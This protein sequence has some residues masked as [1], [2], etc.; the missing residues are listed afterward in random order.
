METLRY[1]HG[2]DFQFAD[3]SKYMDKGS[4][5][6]NGYWQERGNLVIQGGCD[7]SDVK[8]SGCDYTDRYRMFAILKLESYGF[9]KPHCFEALEHCKGNVDD[10]LDL[11]YAQYFPAY[12]KPL[13]NSALDVYSE[14]EILEMRQDEMSSLQSIYDTMFEEQQP[15]RVWQLKLKID[16]LLVHS[17]SE[18]RKR[19][20]ASHEQHKQVANNGKPLALCR[21]FAKGK[22]KYGV[23]CRFSHKTTDTTIN[24]IGGVETK[25]LDPDLDANWF[26]LEIR[27]AAKSRYPFEAP[28]M[29][30]KTTCP[31]IPPM[32]C[33][34]ITRRIAEESQQMAKDGMAS[35][36]TVSDLLQ[37]DDEI[38]TFLRNDRYEFL[39][40]KNSIF[41]V[42]TDADT[43][44]SSDDNSKS[45]S[46]HY[47]K[48]TTGRSDVTKVSLDQRRKDDLNLVQKFMDKQKQTNYKAMLKT[49][50]SL[51]AWSMMTEILETIGRSQVVVISGETG[52]GK[53]TQVPQ[54]ILDEWM[55]RAAMSTDKSSIGHIEI[56]CTQPRRISAIGVAER[57]ADERS[58]KIGNTVGY[59][60]RLENKISTATR[61]T[62][63]TTGILLRRLQS[64]DQLDSIS[65]VLV[66]EV[67]ERSEESD[68]LLLIL[69]E[70]LVKRSDLKVIL[71]SATLNA[72]LFSDYFNGCPVLEIP[73][74]T[75][76]V[77][78][79]F[80]EDILDRSKFVLEADSQ[81][82]RKLNKNEE[83]QLLNELEYADVM[84]ANSAPP[85]SIRDENLPMADLFARYNECSRPTCKT[86]FLMDPMKIN[87]ELIET[88]LKFIVDGGGDNDD[89]PRDGSILIFLP[90]LAEIQTIYDALTDSAEFSPRAGKYI[91]VPLHS[92]LTNEEQSLVFQKPS[93]GRRKI[94][95][96]TNIAETSVTID[97]CV[98]VIDCGQMKEKRFDAN[99][100]MESLDLV[101]VSRANALQRKGRAGRVMPGVCIHLFTK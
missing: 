65:H 89:W 71:M 50:Q 98:F 11:L 43:N 22:C 23:R 45:R 39:N 37:Q 67:H 97:D 92:T 31:D 15:N 47:A 96:S 59:Q 5:L 44:L 6:K 72:K 8:K 82:C 36:Y 86:L 30:L 40:P 57:V 80:L 4:R 63:C 41:H 76:S 12:S 52:C 17:P 77:E 1:I 38:A 78:Q 64:D 83:H 48:G 93:K 24:G 14:S 60:I 75:F 18:Q 99:R 66:D 7:F 61:L 90:G 29:F 62:F 79:I 2:Q 56:V 74:R 68:F 81:Y 95:L 27:F 32:L 35:V 49:R 84:A 42:Y 25:P 91:L 53:S 70:L 69:K 3:K 88:I 33:L 55:L 51:P 46:T 19:K 21:N 10:A 85:R 13:D 26:Y 34:R 20:N 28:M 73:G 58:E 100:N 54:F 87:P 94:V 101:W 9:H 16:H